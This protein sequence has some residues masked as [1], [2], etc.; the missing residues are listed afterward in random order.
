MASCSCSWLAV[1]VALNIV[2][3]I[4]CCVGCV[5]G[6]VMKA[7]QLTQA[8]V[9]QAQPQP[10]DSLKK[11]DDVD[12]AV[13]DIKC[14]HETVERSGNRYMKKTVCKVCKAVIKFERL[15]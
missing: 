10:V 14:R 4:L 9:A 1:S 8:Q 6:V 3:V 11:K 7:S 15:Q 12:D 13:G 2:L 5:L